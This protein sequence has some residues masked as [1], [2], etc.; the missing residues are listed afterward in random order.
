MGPLFRVQAKTDGP[1][2]G[3]KIEP[4]GIERVVAEI[5]WTHCGRKNPISNHMLC[6]ATGKS[7]RAIKEV[8]QSLVVDHGIRIGGARIGED[9]GYFMVMDAED[10]EA[11]VKSYRNQ[12]L[13]MWR[14]LKV[15]C[16]AHALRELHG[17]LTIEEGD[18]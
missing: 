10:L 6:M 14:R 9:H 15:L 11:A 5:I 8:V 2:A 7:E 17:Q 3:S 1:F 4:T 13:S 16:E 18:E 12:I